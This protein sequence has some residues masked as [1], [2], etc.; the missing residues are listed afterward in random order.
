M[1]S[2]LALRVLE[3]EVG[4]VWGDVQDHGDR[5]VEPRGHHRPREPGSWEQRA[6]VTGE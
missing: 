5:A 3:N 1:E 2:K 6:E 4:T